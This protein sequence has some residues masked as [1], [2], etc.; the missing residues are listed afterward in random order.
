MNEQCDC[1]QTCWCLQNQ[2]PTT[3]A[4]VK[5]SNHRRDGDMI[6]N[7]TAIWKQWVWMKIEGWMANNDCC[8]WSKIIYLLC[9]M[10]SERIFIRS[11][12]LWAFIY[13]CCL[14]GRCTNA[15]LFGDWV[16]VVVEIHNNNRRLLALQQLHVRLLP[17]HT[18]HSCKLVAVVLSLLF[19]CHVVMLCCCKRRTTTTQ[20]AATPH[21]LAGWVHWKYCLACRLSDW[22]CAKTMHGGLNWI[23][24]RANDNMT[25]RRLRRRRRRRWTKKK[26]LHAFEHDNHALARSNIVHS[27]VHGCLARRKASLCETW[28]VSDREWNVHGLNVCHNLNLTSIISLDGNMIN[29]FNQINESNRNCSALRLLRLVSIVGWCIWR[30]EWG[31]L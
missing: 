2:Q 19:C 17:M 30:E 12:Q 22:L 25:R 24:R 27:C 15:F 23:R 3:G 18:N 13:C 8:D 14:A 7:R 9:S 4:S 31:A 11:I 26:A 20:Y 6:F 29:D 10:T 28:C 5:K 1:Y 16:N 21:T